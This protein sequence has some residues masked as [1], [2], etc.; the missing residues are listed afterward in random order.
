MLTRVSG[1]L[2]HVSTQKHSRLRPKTPLS[3]LSHHAEV[4]KLRTPAPD[5]RISW[6]APRIRLADRCYVCCSFSSFS[7]V[8]EKVGNRNSWGERRKLRIRTWTEL[9]LS[10]TI[11]VVEFLNYFV[12]LIFSAYLKN[13]LKSSVTV[14]IINSSWFI[15]T[16]LYLYNVT[17]FFFICNGS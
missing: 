3:F 7:V 13:Y 5:R 11:P 2:F 17:N 10:S 1:E 6:C 8:V 14:F 12:F 9:Y 16:L 15:S 4:S